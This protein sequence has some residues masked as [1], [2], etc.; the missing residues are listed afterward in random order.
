MP[1]GLAFSS[2]GV[3]GRIGCV[4]HFLASSFVALSTA[5]FFLAASD[6]AAD[7]VAPLHQL[8]F[9]PGAT[10]WE[11]LLGRADCA[12]SYVWTKH[13]GTGLSRWLLH[14]SLSLV[15][16]WHLLVMWWRVYGG[17]LS[18]TW[19]VS[20]EAQARWGSLLPLQSTPTTA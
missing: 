12:C 20:G 19:I 8:R 14:H 16:V 9:L 15:T 13:S 4:G 11:L 7:A 2:P 1:L 18:S 17:Y 6:I 5:V 10:H 3:G